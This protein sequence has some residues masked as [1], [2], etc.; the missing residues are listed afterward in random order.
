M[1]EHEKKTRIYEVKG[2]LIPNFY[3]ATTVSVKCATTDEGYDMVKRWAKVNFP[4]WNGI[5][6]RS[7]LRHAL[8][9]NPIISSKVGVYVKRK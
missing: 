3:R 5:I 1:A 4:D 8:I 6:Y 7:D 9:K 2:G